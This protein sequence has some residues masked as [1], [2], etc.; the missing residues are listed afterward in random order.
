MSSACP[1]RSSSASTGR[2]LGCQRLGGGHAEVG[3]ALRAAPPAFSPGGSFGDLLDEAEL[4]QLAQVIAGGAGVGAEHL[5][6]GG[7]GRGTVRTEPV[8]D[9]A[10]E[11]MAQRLQSPRVV[12]DDGLGMLA[13]GSSL[14]LQKP[15]C[16]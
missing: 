16:R 11:G 4:L 2:V 6:D 13:H 3:W 14:R 8:Q 9:L 10:A 7:R 12:Q 1:R 5:A 15:F